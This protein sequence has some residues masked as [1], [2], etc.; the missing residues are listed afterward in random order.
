MAALAGAEPTLRSERRL[1][2]VSAA[3]LRP[4]CS[5]EVETA[6]RSNAS[7]SKTLRR[8]GRFSGGGGVERGVRWGLEEG[9]GGLDGVS[10]YRTWRV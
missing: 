3:F 8:T 6:S 7:L 1:S 10:I 4:M 5:C 9:P 2:A